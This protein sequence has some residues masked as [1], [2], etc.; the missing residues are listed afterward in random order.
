[1]IRTRTSMVRA[2]IAGVAV[3]SLTL[4]GAAGCS[5]STP[6]VDAGAKSEVTNPAGTTLTRGTGTS[7]PGT[8]DSGPGTTVA[9][10]PGTTVAGESTT[11]VAGAPPVTGA[12]GAPVTTV[13][14]A[15]PGAVTTVAGVTTTAKPGPP[16]SAGGVT[17]VPVTTVAPTTTPPTTAAPKPTLKASGAGNDNQIHCHAGN[18]NAQ[19]SVEWTATNAT[20][21]AV[22]AGDVGD[23]F[24]APN[25]RISTNLQGTTTPMNLSCS[26]DPIQKTTVTA[27]G[28]GGR[29]TVV[30]TW[31]I[32]K[33]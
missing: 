29:T 30:I 23:A 12:N 15:G 26:P 3:A 17:T 27:D 22:A 14:P 19:V 18:A 5:S 31:A 8:I 6:T 25:A 21:V 20:K 16:T 33:M 7:V 4:A 2:R 24:S 13:A 28:P 11:T 10:D 9:S 1:M 32:M